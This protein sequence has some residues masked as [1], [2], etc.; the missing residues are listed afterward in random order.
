M[1]ETYRGRIDRFQ[2]EIAIAEAKS[3]QTSNL[4]GIVFLGAVGCILTARYAPV[5]TGLSAVLYALGP[6]L[7]VGFFFLVLHHRRITEQLDRATHLKRLNQNA[8][9]RIGRRWAE[10]PVPPTPVE[11][12]DHPTAKDLDL[13]GEVSLF[14]LINAAITPGGRACL[15][16]WLANP[17]DPKTA[18]NR[19]PA[20]AELAPQIDWRQELH[21]VGRDL[22]DHAEATQVIP[23]EAPSFS[24]KPGLM[25]AAR[26]LPIIFTGLVLCQ[27]GGLVAAPWG[28][29]PLLV[30][31]LLN[32]I[33]AKKI[34]RALGAIR[35]EEKAL[36]AYTSV[37]R[38]LEELVAK[39]AWLVHHLDNIEGAHS[40]VEQLCNYATSNAAR[41]SIVY[42]LLKHGLMWDFHVAS[43]VE[44]WH[45]QH[46]PHVERWFEA[47][48]QIEA[49]A[50]LAGLHHDEPDWVFPIFSDGKTIVATGLGHPLIDAK[51][52]VCNDLTID[53]PG[54]FLLVTGSN[55]S[56]KSTLLRSLGLNVMLAQAGAP[57]CST[58]FELPP[59]HI[60][61]SL[62]VEESL[63]EGV[64]FFM[65]ELKRIKSAVQLADDPPPGRVLLYLFDE[66]LR[67]TNSVERQAIVQ[68]L[69]GHLLRRDAI[70][71]ITTHDLALAEI[72][73]LKPAA[74]AVHFRE[75]FTDTP[76]GLK[77]TFDYQL[78]QGLAT[79][80]NAIKL[81]EMI[82][83]DLSG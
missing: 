66:I 56:G 7:L 5:P 54:N 36:Q 77:M 28:L 51:T 43:G 73:E 14:H 35:R 67:G 39:S 58:S 65:A 78:R 82:D 18:A 19:Q 29:I 42:P 27:L 52:R 17:A 24:N 10:L 70:G 53:P 30:M 63:T 49:A 22:H 71:A 23:V 55:M 72:E 62:W 8:V 44:K 9:A 81:L 48:A 33:F 61:T 21:F 3:L 6:I 1:L 57:T 40:A 38:T 47:L 20:V 46:R 11:F 16:N 83:L 74:K 26:L 25:L 76:D 31:V 59:L 69:L 34:D 4:R 37:F 45:A 41:G 64:S 75:G 15:A 68:R 13:F 79:T 50:S 12:E 2:I 60:A 32:K 80:T